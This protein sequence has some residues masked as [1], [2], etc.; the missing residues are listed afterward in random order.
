MSWTVDADGGERLCHPGPDDP[1]RSTPRPGTPAAGRQPADARSCATSTCR[2]A[3]LGQ[4]H[5][6]T[7]WAPQFLTLQARRPLVGRL[8]AV[9]EEPLLRRVRLRLGLGRRL[10]PPRPALLP[11]AAGRRAV[12]AGARHR[13][14]ARDDAVRARPLADQALAALRRPAA[15]VGPPAVHRRHRPRGLER[16]GWM[17]R[18]T[19]C[20][21]TG[22]RTGAAR[23]RLRRPAGALQR[24]K[25]KK[26]QQE[27]RRVA[28][29]A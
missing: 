1:A 6:A 22:R 5:P 24:D 21:S 28:E 10:P 13:L 15:V 26:I 4:R 7:G 20:S 17:M 23:G 12:H 8:C 16:A 2:A 14:L 29:R 3:R 11:Q 19:A 9:P 18:E 25:R 27:R